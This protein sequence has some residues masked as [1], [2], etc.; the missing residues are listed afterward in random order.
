METNGIVVTALDGGHVC[1]GC[2]IM[3]FGREDYQP[4]CEII[5]CICCM[6][7]G[8]RAGV[9]AVGELRISVYE[10]QLHAQYSSVY[11]WLTFQWYINQFQGDL[12]AIII[13]GFVGEDNFEVTMA[14]Q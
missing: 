8:L 13:R 3:L 5:I 11:R 1:F 2:L 12:E 14:G 4:L 6:L 10:F 7:V 9:S